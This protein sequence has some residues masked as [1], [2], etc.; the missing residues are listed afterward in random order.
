MYY[1]IEI[2]I[3]SCAICSSLGPFLDEI[4]KIPLE[5]LQDTL[6]NICAKHI[7]VHKIKSNRQTTST[8][9]TYYY[10]HRGGKQRIRRDQD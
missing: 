9:V 3:Q 10:C 1:F 6:N 4:V 2:C 8:L 7:V 5:K